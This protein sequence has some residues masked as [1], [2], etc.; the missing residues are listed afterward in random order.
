MSSA[1]NDLAAARPTFEIPPAP[2]S[3]RDAWAAWFAGQHLKCAPDVSAV[4]YLPRGAGE[5]EIRFV[6]LSEQ[7]AGRTDET[8][9]EAVTFGVGRDTGGRHVLAIVDATPEQWE[10]MRAGAL[11]P[12]DGWETAGGRVF[13]AG[14][15]HAR[16]AA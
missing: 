6:E 12:P 15:A 5:E 1:L 9:R 8:V 10:R 13:E 14:A 3:G 2:G 16:A 7:V 4:I 11:A